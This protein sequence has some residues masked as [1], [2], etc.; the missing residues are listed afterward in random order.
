MVLSVFGHPHSGKSL[1]AE[2]QA[3]LSGDRI[4]YVGT[5]PMTH[6]YRETIL[7]H[8]ARR[9]SSWDCVELTGDCLHDKELI[10]KSLPRSDAT[11]IDGLSFYAYRQM[12]LKN[13]NCASELARPLLSAARRYAGRMFLIDPPI[14]AT[15]PVEVASA[16]VRLQSAVLTISD[17]IAWFENGEPRP[18]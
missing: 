8:K 12:A 17:T 10:L 11:I 2:R 13:G 9:P 3:S 18:I 6:Y 1:Y 5:L 16:L 7:Q 14:P 4:L 15:V